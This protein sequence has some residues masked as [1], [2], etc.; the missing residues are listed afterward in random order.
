MDFELIAAGDPYFA[1]IDPAQ[2]NQPYLSQDLRVFRAAPA[3]NS[4]PFP[5][6]PTFWTDS[7]AGAY[8]YIQALLGYLNGTPS[9][10]NPARHRSVHA[11][12]RPA[13]G[14]PDRHLGGAASC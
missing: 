13:G 7:V 4:V 11:V 14:G 8:G 6:G 3:I 1:N 12:A 2:N 10:T 5:G 9:F